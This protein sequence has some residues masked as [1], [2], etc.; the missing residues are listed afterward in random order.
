[1]SF[2]FRDGHQ[3]KV[4]LYPVCNDFDSYGVVVDAHME[5]DRFE[6]FPN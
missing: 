6:V 5:S 2:G 3:L 4:L 1:M